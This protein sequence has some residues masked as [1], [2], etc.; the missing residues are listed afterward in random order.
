MDSSS[1][2]ASSAGRLW[3][4]AAS[5]IKSRL[6]PQLL[7]K[8][9]RHHEEKQEAKK[10]EEMKEEG[11]GRE[12]KRT[13]K[14][15]SAMGGTAKGEKADAEKS[16]SKQVKTCKIDDFDVENCIN[17]IKDIAIDLQQGEREG[18][19]RGGTGGLWAAYIPAFIYTYRHHLSFVYLSFHTP[20]FS[21]HK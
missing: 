17:V 7:S 18:C 21:K 3:T 2:S 10:E 13:T 5:I 20:A 4:K 11:R 9:N 8:H 14:V 1:S 6:E 16:R 15:E 12:R 19:V